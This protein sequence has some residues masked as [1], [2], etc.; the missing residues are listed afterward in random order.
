[1]LAHNPKKQFL[2]YV[3]YNF[4]HLLFLEV[5]LHGSKF[6]GGISRGSELIFHVFT[7]VAVS[8]KKKCHV[9]EISQ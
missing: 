1:M 7:S 3:A 2:S 8:R 5:I 9:Q 4:S 6:V